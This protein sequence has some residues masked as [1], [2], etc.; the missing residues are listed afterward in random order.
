MSQ[1]LVNENNNNR[2]GLGAT[3]DRLNDRYLDSSYIMSSFLE[4]IRKMGHRLCNRELPDKFLFPQMALGPDSGDVR[5]FKRMVLKGRL[6]P[7]YPGFEDSDA[8]PGVRISH[9]LVMS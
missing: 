8:A 9:E 6:A 7:F 3:I 4:F 5:V 1:G 2:L